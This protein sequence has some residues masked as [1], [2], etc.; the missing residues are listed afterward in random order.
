MSKPEEITPETVAR[1]AAQTLGMTLT[2]ADA[3]AT[4]EMLNALARDMQAFR[5]MGLGDDEP[6]AIYA[7]VE[8][9]P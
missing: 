2:P 3:T 6:A 5:Q 4:A 1:M 7:A 8:G 9:E